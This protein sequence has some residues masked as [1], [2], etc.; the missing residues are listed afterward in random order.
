VL[1]DVTGPMTTLFTLFAVAPLLGSHQRPAHCYNALG[2]IEG[3]RWLSDGKS[4]HVEE[5]RATPPASD[6]VSFTFGKT[7]N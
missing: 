3:L 5:V 6:F 2:V 7:L 4:F 1:A